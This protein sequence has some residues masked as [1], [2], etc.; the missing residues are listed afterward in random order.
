MRTSLQILGL[1]R[2]IRTVQV[3]SALAGEGKTTTASNLAVVLA[4]SGKRVV[5][6]DTD[7]RH[8]RLHQVFDVPQQPGLTDLV[9]GSAVDVAVKRCPGPLRPAREWH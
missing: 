3:T 1:D 8:P 2:P 9:L 6:V 4:Q 5:I 7:Q